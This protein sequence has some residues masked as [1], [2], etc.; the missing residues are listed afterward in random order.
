MDFASFLQVIR[1][2]LKLVVAGLMVTAVCALGIGSLM[3]PTYEAQASVLLYSPSN[4][5]GTTDGVPPTTAGS[6]NPLYEIG[7]LGVV[8]DVMSQRMADPAVVQDVNNRGAGGGTWAVA[9]NTETRSPLLL[10]T[11]DAPSND[12]AITTMKNVLNV[13]DEQLRVLQ[14]QKATTPTDHVITT[15]IVRQDTSAA[16]KHGSR[17]RALAAVLVLGVIASF[18][19]PFVVEALE[20]SRRKRSEARAVH[21]AANGFGAPV[22]EPNSAGSAGAEISP[23]PVTQLMPARRPSD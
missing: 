2:H 16:A 8:T 5:S 15:Q 12:A 17:A 22:L 4:A 20:A 3:K 13:I 23:E 11:A 14:N 1:R 10:V 9:Q 18:S 6:Q 7:D 19:L 21:A